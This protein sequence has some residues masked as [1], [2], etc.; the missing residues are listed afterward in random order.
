MALP[1][2]FAAGCVLPSGRFAVLGDGYDD[3][4]DAEAFDPVS[5]RGSRCPACRAAW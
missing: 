1:R 4:R 2:R 3:Y 5:R